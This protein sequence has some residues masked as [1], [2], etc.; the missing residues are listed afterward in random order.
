[1]S[2]REK[3]TKSVLGLLRESGVAEAY[4]NYRTLGNGR[5]KAITNSKDSY[6][7]LLPF[8][9]NFIDHH[10][11]MYL[12][13]LNRRNAVNGVVKISQGGMAGT[14]CDVKIVAQATILSHSCS[15]ILAHNH[16]SGNVMPSH[17][18]IKLT[19]R[20][21][22]ALKLLDVQLL[23]HLILTEEKYFSFAD[24]GRI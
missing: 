17:Q 5:K 3:E 2:R 9:V 13:L 14:V 24:E 21:K 22:D 18:D 16:P 1:M 11:E 15:C 23:D 19:D 12:M 20:V 8:F 7:T 6:E 4:L 10:E